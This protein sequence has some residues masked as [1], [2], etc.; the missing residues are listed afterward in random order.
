MSANGVGLPH[1]STM[2]RT[3][4]PHGKRSLSGIALR[5]HLLG[6]GQALCIIFAIYLAFHSS[7]LWRLPFYLGTLVLFHFLEFY[8]TAMYNTSTATVS[9]FLLT[10]NGKEYYAAH[11]AALIEYFVMQYFF[12]GRPAFLF[13]PLAI[14]LGTV[15]VMLGQTVRSVAMAQAGTNFNHH[16]Q[17]KRNEGHELVT[18]GI[19]AYIRHPAYFGFFWWGLGT[20]ILLGNPLCLV[21][22]SVV[23][24]KFFSLRIAREEML[25]KGFFGDDYLRYRA[26]TSVWIPFIP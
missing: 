8:V 16:V 18:I 15:L 17:T 14:A 20:Q 19:Y 13:Q 1:R 5:S 23:L 25:L 21:A 2:D 26:R 7:P 11:V 22:Y 9:S 3:F 24:W 4:L 12:P 10:S 6:V